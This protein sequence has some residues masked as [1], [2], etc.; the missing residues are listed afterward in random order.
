MTGIGGGIDEWMNRTWEMRAL[1]AYDRAVESVIGTLRRMGR[2]GL[3]AATSIA[4]G[5]AKATEATGKWL[6][7]RA[8]WLAKGFA[9]S[10]VAATVWDLARGYVA[11]ARRGMP[12]IRQLEYTETLL[13]SLSGS[14]TKATLAMRAM[15]EVRAAGTPHRTREMQQALLVLE[16]TGAQAFMTADGLKALSEA[17]IVAD[18]ELDRTATMLG[19]L[20]QAFR[21]ASDGSD[22]SRRYL[23]ETIAPLSE[24][25]I[26]SQEAAARLAELAGSGA[27]V[28]ALNSAVEIL[29]EELGRFDG[30]IDAVGDTYDG[31]GRRIEARSEQ[32]A[33]HMARPF[34]R[35]GKGWR[36]F[37]L[38]FLD[39]A[40]ELLTAG[41]TPEDVE[42]IFVEAAARREE[43]QRGLAAATRMPEP[44]TAT[45]AGPAGP[46]PAFEGAATWRATD[47]QRAQVDAAMAARE[48]GQVYEELERRLNALTQAEED[49][50]DGAGDLAREQREWFIDV[51][52]HMLRAVEDQIAARNADTEALRTSTAET[53]RHMALVFEEAAAM[54][55]AAAAARDLSEANERAGI[56][57]GRA[58]SPEAAA[59]LEDYRAALDSIRDVWGT[60]DVDQRSRAWQGYVEALEDAQ[61]SGV[62]LTEDERRLVDAWRALGQE[63]RRAIAQNASW[64]T[65]AEGVNDLLTSGT[66][67]VVQAV[68]ATTSWDYALAKLSGTVGG[69]V[70]QA[71]REFTAL[72]AAVELAQQKVIDR[73]ASMTDVFLNNNDRL[74][75][76]LAAVSVAFTA[77]AQAAS[78]MASE[79]GGAAQAAASGANVLAGVTA[80]AP[81]G[82]AGMIVGGLQAGIGELIGA[83]GRN[84]RATE[85]ARRAYEEAMSRARS[86]LGLEDTRGN[87]RDLARL[88][89]GGW[90]ADGRPVQRLG[91]E[92]RRRGFMSYGRALSDA[93][94]M[95]INL[96]DELGGVTGLEAE[97][98]LMAYRWTLDLLE[99]IRGE[100]ERRLRVVNEITDDVLEQARAVRSDLQGSYQSMTAALAD[101]ASAADSAFNVSALD[102]AI[103][104]MRE[105]GLLTQD[106]ADAYHALADAAHIDWRGMVAL[107]EQFGIGQGHLGAGFEQARVSGLGGELAAAF[108]TLTDAGGDQL[109]VAVGLMRTALDDRGK[110]TGEGG[111]A[112]LIER[113]AASGAFVPVELKPALDALAAGGIMADQIAAVRYGDPLGE[114]RRS[115]H[116]L[117]AEVS[118][119]VHTAAI[120]EAEQVIESIE[121]LRDAQIEAIR[122]QT[123]QLVAAIEAGRFVAG[124]I[125]EFL[126]RPVPELVNI[127]RSAGIDL[128]GGKTGDFSFDAE[129]YRAALEG[130]LSKL[131]PDSTQ[132]E[133]LVAGVN[134]AH[135]LEPDTIAALADAHR[136]NL[137]VVF[138]V[139]GARVSEVV[140]TLANIH[141]V[142]KVNANYNWSADLGV[143]AVK[144]VLDDVLT[145]VSAPPPPQSIRVNFTL[146][147]ADGQTIIDK[148]VDALPSNLAARSI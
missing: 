22:E 36:S 41:P 132:W 13:E 45:P 37:K 135:G 119:A 148:V 108:E 82:P 63:Q 126:G 123:A 110:E 127:S 142:A 145:E 102:A 8:G 12:L 25:G 91:Q 20:L 21:Q 83:L 118:E 3:T 43:I 40:F 55:D 139:D 86:T 77:A 71:V 134:K 57:L 124:D 7:G 129:A 61:Q 4:E 10:A 104:R 44:R 9:L 59:H 140:S 117:L 76:G 137:S 130:E 47:E 68:E 94:G 17:A 95:G 70:E 32:I 88:W 133:D 51:D 52:R 120:D 143:W 24:L 42:T 122:G 147:D 109:R 92:D 2:A 121:S 14:A 116:D 58:V 19:E 84:T 131:T 15:E 54:R 38:S 35:W 39:M 75:T 60:L 69:P 138:G 128:I 28:L 53:D 114:Q 18:T 105:L 112:M 26:V 16:R 56:L 64:T 136:G 81:L 78:A 66:L 74:L 1:R 125:V 33:M 30:V 115:L 27:G 34:E 72:L 79:V 46:H 111:L 85:E 50:A 90:D 89:S 93:S 97:G 100:E 48:L 23:V 73:S 146:S 62:Q 98:V 99:D 6:A 67:R 65:S 101:L 141:G 96:R 107:T 106:T 31:L 5:F 144:D 103:D 29:R 49:A 11:L 87:L 80:G 113:A